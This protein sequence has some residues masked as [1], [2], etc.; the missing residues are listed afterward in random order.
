VRYQ[1]ALRPDDPLSVVSSRL[2]VT[3]KR[4]GVSS[5]SSAKL[6]AAPARRASHLQLTTNNRQLTTVISALPRKYCQDAPQLLTDGAQVRATD[7]CLEQVLL[8]QRL[9]ALNGFAG[10]LLPR[11]VDGES[12][13]VKQLPNLENQLYVTPP[14][15]PMPGGTLGGA[16]H[17]KLRF[18]VAENVRLGMSKFA[19]LADPKVKFLRDEDITVCVCGCGPASGTGCAA[20][21]HECLIG[22]QRS[23][24]SLD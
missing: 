6:C 13:L 3:N 17:W 2:L 15:E 23:P 1:A 24:V 14:V 20:L 21:C 19:D 22:L 4:R 11:T 9:F 8:L 5:Q 16:E 12:L 10:E 18:P 7:G